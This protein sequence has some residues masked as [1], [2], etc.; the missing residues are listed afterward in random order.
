M[1]RKWE[2]I[3]REKMEESEWTLP[4]SVYAE[5]R[6]RRDAAAQAPGRKRVPQL[7]LA[8]PAVAAVLAAVLLLHRPAEPGDGFQVVHPAR[9][10]VAEAIGGEGD[11]G[12]AGAAVELGGSGDGSVGDSDVDSIAF[13]GVLTDVDE[14]VDSG[15]ATGGNEAVDSGLVA[16]TDEADGVRVTASGESDADVVCGYDIAE[17]D[18]PGSSDGVAADG[19]AAAPAVTSPYKPERAPAKVLNLKVA[20]AVGIVAAGGLVASLVSPFIQGIG[21]K[22]DDPM[23]MGDFNSGGNHGVNQP[24]GDIL[25]ESSHEMPLRLG[26]SA[27]APLADRLNFVTGLDYSLYTS[28]FTFAIPGRMTQRAHYLGIPVRLDWTVAD[29]GW[30]DVYLGCGFEGEFCLKAALDGTP[31]SKD[32]FGLSLLGAG[33]LQLNLNERT[34]LYLE[35]QISWRLPSD[36]HMLQTYRS[37]NPLMFSLTGG[38]RFSF[39]R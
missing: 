21:T 3:I 7:W 2:D 37:E 20:P 31:I 17:A 4:E 38:L 35:P 19:D 16:C 5:F 12:F 25:N 11:S 18:E 27:R 36:S 23:N 30:L 28:R 9:G 13:S 33:G 14:T 6:S 1:M 24:G 29:I 15:D 8:I 10:T 22:G 26:L 32:R 34:G 39:G